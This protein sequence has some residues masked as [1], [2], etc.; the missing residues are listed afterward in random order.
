M[1]TENENPELGI[2]KWIVKSLSL[3]IILLMVIYVIEEITHIAL[4]VDTLVAILIIL[5]IAFVHESLHYYQAVKLGYRPKWWRTRFK[6]GFELIPHSNRRQWVEDKKKIANAPYYFAIPVSIAI[7]LIGL[8]FNLYGFIVA[9][10]GSL[11]MHGLS[12]PSEGQ[13]KEKA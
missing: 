8:Y 12:Y 4:L 1:E 7:L 6:M 11:I 13:E 9:G 5:S 3:T 10:I 2:K